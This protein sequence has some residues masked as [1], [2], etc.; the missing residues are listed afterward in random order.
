[1]SKGQGCCAV[2]LPVPPGCEGPNPACWHWWVLK[3]APG[4]SQVKPS[5]V[6]QLCVCCLGMLGWD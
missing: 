6:A 5:A 4:S 1:M 2:Q 3:G